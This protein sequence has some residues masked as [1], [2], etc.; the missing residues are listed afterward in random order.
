MAWHGVE[1]GTGRSFRLLLPSITLVCMN[2][3]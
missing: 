2:L 3:I 1:P